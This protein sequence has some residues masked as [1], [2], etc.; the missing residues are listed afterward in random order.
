M[1][2]RGSPASSGSLGPHAPRRHAQGRTHAR[3]RTRAVPLAVDSRS[4]SG[5]AGAIGPGQPFL[6]S[7]T[8]ADRRRVASGPGGR[9]SSSAS[10]RSERTVGIVGRTGVRAAE[11]SAG[12]ASNDA[13]STARGSETA[14]PVNVGWWRRWGSTPRPGRTR[15][16]AQPR[17][18]RSARTDSVPWRLV[19]GGGKAPRTPGRGT[20]PCGDVR[21][22][23]LGGCS[24]KLG[25]RLLEPRK[26]RVWNALLKE[27]LRATYGGARIRACPGA[28]SPRPRSGVAPPR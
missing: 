20:V 7:R 6:A 10:A 24:T 12:F 26:G 1:L 17:E 25:P 4:V 18:V 13:R 19:E 28:R 2:P 15:R 3:P 5:P 23:S 9:G 22:P 16:K 21:E 27:R 14:G 8:G 11:R